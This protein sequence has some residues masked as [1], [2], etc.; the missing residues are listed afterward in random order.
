MV[1]AD[2]CEETVKCI[3]LLDIPGEDGDVVC[4][5][6]DVFKGGWPRHGWVCFV[7]A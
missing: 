7:S 1:F 3:D 6:R 4:G 2:G 5:G